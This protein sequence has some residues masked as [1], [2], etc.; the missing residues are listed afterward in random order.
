MTHPNE[1]HS[2]W[3]DK[4]VIF[5]EVQNRHGVPGFHADRHAWDLFE[6]DLKKEVQ[7]RTKTSYAIYVRAYDF[8]KYPAI[9]EAMEAAG[10]R[11][12]SLNEAEALIAAGEAVPGVPGAKG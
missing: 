7:K 6:G 10:A 5:W 1:V 9:Y 12:I 11:V 4:E 8:G 2:D 3:H